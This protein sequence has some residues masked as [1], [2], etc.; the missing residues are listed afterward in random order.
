[1]VRDTGTH[2]GISRGIVASACQQTRRQVARAESLREITDADMVRGGIDL[3]AYLQVFWKAK[4]NYRQRQ[5]ETKRIK[6]PHLAG[7]PD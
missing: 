7:W 5:E 1:V 4:Y 6:C 3:I 2:P